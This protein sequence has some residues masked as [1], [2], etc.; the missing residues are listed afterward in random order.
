MEEMTEAQAKRFLT[1]ET[2]KWAWAIAKRHIDVVFERSLG[3][4]GGS[5]GARTI[6]YSRKKLLANMGN[7]IGLRD[8]AIHEVIHLKIPNHGNGFQ[9]EYAK[10]IRIAREVDDYKTPDRVEDKLTKYVP[11]LE[12]AHHIKLRKRGEGKTLEGKWKVKYIR[13]TLIDVPP[14][15]LDPTPHKAWKQETVRTRATTKTE[16]L[17]VF[18]MA[19]GK[20]YPAWLLRYVRNSVAHGWK[21]EEYVERDPDRIN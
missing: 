20:N 4:A 3:T 14:N 2:K 12:S 21:V 1:S 11:T 18:K 15:R 13:M 10:W 9:V 16:A 6:Y 8:L 17:K 19:M 5:C 7:K